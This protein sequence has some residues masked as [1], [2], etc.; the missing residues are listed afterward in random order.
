MYPEGVPL[1]AGS[2]A[3]HSLDR[4]RFESGLLEMPGH[5]I[6]GVGDQC[7]PFARWL[8]DAGAVAGDPVVPEIACDSAE[9]P[10]ISRFLAILRDR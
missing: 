9:K 8:E 4:L 5:A 6:P 3:N 10:E 1:P 7:V 2:S